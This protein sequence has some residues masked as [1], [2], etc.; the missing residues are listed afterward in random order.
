M[1]GCMLV[2][3]HQLVSTAELYED[4]VVIA[5]PDADLITMMNVSHHGPV[6][7]LHESYAHE[8]LKSSL[9]F[10][11]PAVAVV[12]RCPARTEGL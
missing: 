1:Q 3:M 11:K 8:C 4:F 9:A 5:V 2:C 7:V 12:S 10:R 6:G